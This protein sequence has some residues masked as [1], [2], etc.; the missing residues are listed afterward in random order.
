MPESAKPSVFISYSHDSP[1][2]GAAV[3]ELAAELRANGIPCVTDQ[4]VKPPRVGWLRWARLEC[5]KAA[6]V[7]VV[8]TKSYGQ[9]FDR[10]PS[11]GADWEGFVLTRELYNRGGRGEKFIPVLFR[12]GDAAHIPDLLQGLT[13]FDVSRAEER[14]NLC[15]RLSQPPAGRV[16]AVAAPP[17]AVAPVAK[18]PHAA[19][20]NLP[21]A[22]NRLFTGREHD[23][24]RLAQ[25]ASKGRPVVITQAGTS[26]GGIGKSQ[27]ALAYAY[28]HIADYRVI[29]WI[30]ADH[31]MVIAEDLV[32]LGQALSLPGAD[33]PDQPAALATVMGWLRTHGDWLLIYDNADAGPEP[34]KPYMPPSPSGHLLITSRWQAGWQGAESVELDLFPLFEAVSFLLKRSGQTD[35]KAATAVAS[36]LGLQPL[37]LEQAGAFCAQ[38]QLPLADYLERFRRQEAKPLPEAAVKPGLAAALELSI[39]RLER[40][41]SAAA[42]ALTLA[43]CLA[44]DH[45]PEAL[46]AAAAGDAAWP[47]ARELLLGAALLSEGNGSLSIH[48]VTQWVVRQWM[49][50]V[51][52]R[53]AVARALA[54]V[55][56]AF[57]AE[58][59]T[60]SAWPAC[61]QLLSHALAVLDLADLHHVEPPQYADL[62]NRIGG[63][64]HNRSAYAAAAMIKERAARYYRARNDQTALA[65]ILLSSGLTAEHL[66]DYGLALRQYK[67]ALALRQRPDAPPVNW[68]ARLWYHVGVMLRQTGAKGAVRYYGRARRLLARQLDLIERKGSAGASLAAGFGDLGR[69]LVGLMA[70]ARPGSRAMRTY[71]AEAARCLERVVD[72]GMG[73]AEVNP[74]YLC[75]AA[76]QLGLLHEQLGEPEEARHSYERA[77]QAFADADAGPHP[78]VGKILAKLSWLKADQGDLPAARQYMVKALLHAEQ[79][80]PEGH[81][82]ITM[83]RERLTS[84]S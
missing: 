56:A 38:H 81:P 35:R 41:S 65:W 18:S 20:H 43:A 53:A 74:L 64:L 9:R 3:R 5:T 23:L 1:A 82:D 27:L 17:P 83:Y 15:R 50:A 34:L 14:I 76:A 4:E 48:S 51:Q 79:Y 21:A 37:A 7:L 22:R 26:L 71:G 58:N 10:E 25:K 73:G 84:L 33:G 28:Q 6:Y 44:P 55:T 12:R 62:C 30:R 68:D 52:R 67:E 2:H 77:L 59:A 16:E 57:P 36:A 61:G 63:Y 40:R 8:C 49:G 69:T 45:L 80:R 66:G 31:P 75:A 72:L 70:L 42:R 39:T 78:A 47:A 11:R 13:Y 24:E 29:W 19:C 60:P 32:Q 54:A 46:L